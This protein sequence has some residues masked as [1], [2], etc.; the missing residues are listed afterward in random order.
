MEGEW[1]TGVRSGG[2]EVEE[3]REGE[4]ETEGE[5]ERED[6]AGSGQGGEGRR[7]SEKNECDGVNDEGR[8]EGVSVR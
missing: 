6:D 2:L 4:E 3:E 1:V 8:E 7:M 5:E